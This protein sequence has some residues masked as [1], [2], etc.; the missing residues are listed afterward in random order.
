MQLIPELPYL[1]AIGQMEPVT[2]DRVNHG[3]KENP[4]R[5]QNCGVPACPTNGGL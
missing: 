3:L 5:V 2:K 1:L 4:G